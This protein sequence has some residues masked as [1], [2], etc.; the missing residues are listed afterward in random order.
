MNDTIDVKI[1]ETIEEFQCP[2]CTNGSDTKC[3]TFKQAT[4]GEHCSNHSAGTMILGSGKI[5][6]GLPNGFNKVRNIPEGLNT[7]IRIFTSEMAKNA[8]NVFNV[9]TWTM[10]YKGCLLVRTYLPRID[11]TYVDIIPDF[12]ASD[13]DFQYKGDDIENFGEQD[14]KY[15]PID[16]SK[17]QNLID[18]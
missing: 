1:V 12:K 7:N 8:F 5:N 3:G 4:Y 15:N 2:G 18:W 10:E 6:L 17:F 14:E 16:V 9:P 11:M 13:I